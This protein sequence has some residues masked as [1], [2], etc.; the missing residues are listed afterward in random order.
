MD[1]KTYFDRAKADSDE[2]TRLQ[3]ELDAQFN[4]GTDEGIQG[5]IDMQPA[6][7]AAVKKANE[8]N[9]LYLTMRDAANRSGDAAALFVSDDNSD[10]DAENDGKV[11]TLAAFNA[12]TPRKRLDFSKAGG[13][14]EN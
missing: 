13:R 1:L 5:A 12:L 3:N 8:S 4:L 6:L 11:L 2:A 14:I 9:K 10:E 7:E